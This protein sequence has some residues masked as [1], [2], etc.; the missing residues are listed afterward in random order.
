MAVFHECVTVTTQE[1][2]IRRAVSW[3]NDL[4]DNL[5]SGDPYVDRVA[6]LLVGSRPISLDSCW[7]DGFVAYLHRFLQ[8]TVDSAAVASHL[9]L[10]SL[11]AILRTAGQS[12]AFGIEDPGDPGWQH[13]ISSGWLLI[14]TNISRLSKHLSVKFIIIYCNGYSES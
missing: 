4:P 7:I 5:G 10:A 13:V 14:I 11:A 2:L 9:S 3:S 6:K 12:R 1:L 8:S